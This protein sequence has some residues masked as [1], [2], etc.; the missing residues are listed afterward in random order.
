[1]SPAEVTYCFIVIVFAYTLR[2]GTGFGA[3]IAM[4]LLA[5]VVPMKILVPGWSVLSVVAGIDILR[6][7]YDKIAW[8]DLMPLMPSCLL[9]IVLGLVFY[10]LLDSPTLARGLGVLVVLYGA[11]SLRA[12][13]RPPQ[14]WQ[15]PP[16]SIA[17]L[18]GLIGGAVGTTFGALTSLSFAMYFD[19][20]R[21]PV[22]Q[23]RATMSAAL[24]AMGLVRGLGYFGLGEFTADVWLLLAITLP[25]TLIGIYLGNRIFA[26]LEEVKFR[27]L[28]S[29][30]LMVSGFALLVK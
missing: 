13:M 2:G 16:T 6:R 22:D 7:D 5:L 14:E 21:I 3:A 23:F 17:R 30:T 12:T 9:G 26:E 29:L 20:I 10:K 18:S 19:A 27:R 8:A 28:V 11:F 15:V 4:P 1:L 24:V 25:M